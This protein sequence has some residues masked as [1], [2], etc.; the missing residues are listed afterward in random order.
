MRI[1]TTLKCG[2]PLRLLKNMN[3]GSLFYKVFLRVKITLFTGHF[4][5]STVF[6][7]DA[8]RD[9]VHLY[10]NNEQLHRILEKTQLWATEEV[11]LPTLVKLLGYEIVSNPCSFEYVK[12]RKSYTPEDINDALNTKDA[13]WIHPI[14]RRYENSHRKY[15]REYFN[16]YAKE[17]QEENCTGE[18]M[19]NL[20]LSLPLINSI[21]NIEG[22]LVIKKQICLLQLL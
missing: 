12:Y 14:E 15:I 8:V 17:K 13:Y 2:Q 21:R 9:L 5:P 16:H 19:P 7:A 6:T 10:N 18:S 4:W 11:I 1:Q 20:L 3:Y 22:W